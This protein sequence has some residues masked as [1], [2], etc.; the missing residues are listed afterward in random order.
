MDTS[1]ADRQNLRV[2]LLLVV[3]GVIMMV[4]AWADWLA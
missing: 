3:F 1:T 4:A 2:W